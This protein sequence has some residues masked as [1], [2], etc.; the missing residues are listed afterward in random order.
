MPQR[1]GSIWPTNSTYLI[2]IFIAWLDLNPY[3]VLGAIAGAAVLVTAAT[4]SPWRKFG[5]FSVSCLC[6]LA[7]SHLVAN[8][9]EGITPDSVSA[10]EAL[11]A[12]AAICAVTGLVILNRLK[13]AAENPQK[14]AAL[15]VKIKKTLG[16]YLAGDDKRD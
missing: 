6:G 7:G 13:W 12:A 16:H 11:G 8:I 15:F 3:Q 4:G 5:D 14:A 9:I 1:L 10:D 2:G